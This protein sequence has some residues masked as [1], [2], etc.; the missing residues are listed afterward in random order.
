MALKTNTAEDRGTVTAALE[1][2]A[3]IVGL[4]C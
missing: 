4:H 2:E 1:F 3:V